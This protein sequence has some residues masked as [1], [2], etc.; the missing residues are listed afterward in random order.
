[1][2]RSVYIWTQKCF[3][4]VAFNSIVGCRVSGDGRGAETDLGVSILSKAKHAI[5][6]AFVA[7]VESQ[8]YGTIQVSQIAEQAGVARATFYL[9]YSTKEE[10]LLAYIDDMFQ[11]FYDDIEAQLAEVELFEVST[12]KKMFVLFE[13]E[14]AF[15]RVLTQ[16]DVRPILYG[17]FQGYLSRIFGRLL[18]SAPEANVPSKDMPFLI[19]FCAGGSLAMLGSWVERDFQP[20]AEVMGEIYFNMLMDGMWHMLG[21]KSEL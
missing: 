8:S 11:R 6:T 17:R 1:M 14:G 13:E 10:L 19:D 20:A 2:C 21:L 5:D 16:P 15:S 9:H 7:L 18:R 4:L 3:C 12:A